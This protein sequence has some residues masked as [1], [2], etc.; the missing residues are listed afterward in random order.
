MPRRLK[1]ARQRALITQAALESIG[2]RAIEPVSTAGSVD[3]GRDSGGTTEQ[4]ESLAMTLP[5]SVEVKLTDVQFS[6]FQRA[7][8]ESQ[9]IA[10]NDR[11]AC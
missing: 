6:N 11:E 3:L 8:A 1:P 10:K 9:L 5:E 7:A 2:I 4:L